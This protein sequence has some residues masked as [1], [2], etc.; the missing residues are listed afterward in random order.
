M[1]SRRCDDK[2]EEKKLMLKVLNEF[3]V[4]NV[5]HTLILS[6]ADDVYTFAIYITMN[7][8][9]A[10]ISAHSRYGIKLSHFAVF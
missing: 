10:N 8:I 9:L 2:E 6:P 1:L 5:V 3:T 4:Y 7:L